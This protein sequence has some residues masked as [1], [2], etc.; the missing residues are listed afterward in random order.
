M[1]VLFHLLLCSFCCF[2][3]LFPAN[4]G[5]PCLS[6]LG[7]QYVPALPSV[8]PPRAVNI[9]GAPHQTVHVHH[10]SC[11][12]SNNCGS[13]ETSRLKATI[14][15]GHC[16]EPRGVLSKAHNSSVIDITLERYDSR[17]WPTGTLWLVEG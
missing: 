5:K 16:S 11:R 14:A 10:T 9:G 13:H 4:W 15:S 6:T 17:Q 8:E 12:N 7:Q 1:A 2:T 3:A